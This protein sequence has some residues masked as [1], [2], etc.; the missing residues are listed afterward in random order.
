[1]CGSGAHTLQEHII[2]E[3]LAQRAKLFTGLLM[4]LS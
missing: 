4:E 2:V 1:V 3:T